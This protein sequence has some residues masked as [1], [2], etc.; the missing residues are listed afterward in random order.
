MG[1]LAT[2]PLSSRASSSS[3]RSAEFPRRDPCNRPEALRWD[4]QAK[5]AIDEAPSFHLIPG[6]RT[7]LCSQPVEKFIQARRPQDDLEDHDLKSADTSTGAFPL[8]P[9]GPPPPIT[10]EAN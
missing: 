9:F 3:L 6:V 1:S 7:V 5:A 2:A 8:R 4:A 10:G